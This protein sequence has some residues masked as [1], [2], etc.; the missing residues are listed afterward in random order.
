MAAPHVIK[1]YANRRLYDAAASRHVTL[2]DLRELVA[3]GESI[4]VI[5]DKTGDDITRTV[6]LQII[7]EQEQFGHPILSI[8]VLE[9]LIR[10]YGN[11]MQEFMTRYLE[12]SMRNFGEQQAAAQAQLARLM[13]ATPL[14]SIADIARQNLDA[15]TR[16]QEAMMGAMSGRSP[17]P[18]TPPAASSEAPSDAKS[19]R[20]PGESRRGR[21][22]QGSGR[23]R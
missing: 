22:S 8:P 17:A 10:F 15:W 5:D 23:P 16:M 4:Q 2:D 9:A 18:Q 1:K 6:L 11:S 7:A 19:E 13:S 14:T 12:E 3:K 20:A 21:E